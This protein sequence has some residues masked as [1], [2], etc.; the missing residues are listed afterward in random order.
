MASQVQLPVLL[1]LLPKV[2]K[3]IQAEQ[4]R[5][6]MQQALAAGL[7]RDLFNQER[8]QV[9][10]LKKTQETYHVRPDE[11]RDRGRPDEHAR[12]EKKPRDNPDD[13]GQQT[14]PWSGQIINI[15]V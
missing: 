11:E 1:S 9:S 4:D 3:L 7:M 10:Q 12:R 8:Q 2:G 14:D 6:G 15:K 5:P 13:P